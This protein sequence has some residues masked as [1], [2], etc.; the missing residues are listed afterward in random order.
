MFDSKLKKIVF[1]LPTLT[2]GG[3]E[4]VMSELVN[5]I[6][7]KDK[8]EC[9]LVIYGKLT[10]DF[11][12]IEDKVIIHRPDFIFN[13]TKRTLSTVKTMQ[14]I[15]KTIKRI[16]PESVL[17]FGEYW[18][19]LVL[20]SLIGTKYP[21]FISDRSSPEM[22]LGKMQETLRCALYPKAKGLIA[23]T[24]KSLEL[25]YLKYAKLNTKTIGNPIRMI[26]NENSSVIRENIVV[27]VGRLIDTKHFDR[28]INIFAKINNK[29]WKLIIIGGDSNKQT[30]SMILDKQ[31]KE[32][33]LTDNIILA[34]R[35]STVDEYLLKASIFDFT[36]S[37]EGFPNV[38]GEA[39]SAGLPVVSYDCIA[40]PSDM[41][42]DGENGYLIP[43]FDDALFQNRLEELMNNSDKR[44]KMGLNALRSIKQF[45]VEKIGEQYYNFIMNKNE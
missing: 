38:I 37:S 45:S 35:Q 31:I 7:K 28:L 11:Y 6:S 23:Q 2:A 5:Y 44:Q 17:S 14:F 1:T 41:I 22:K 18:N 3:M 34:G 21:V 12:K 13:D 42:E 43:L 15:R 9:H 10:T 30:N 19:N 8:V 39:M 20:L 24:N 32:L 26:H 4:R 40:G 27:S 25:A 33:G 36:S 29:D 16:N